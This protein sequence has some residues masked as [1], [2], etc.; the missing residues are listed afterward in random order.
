[1]YLPGTPSTEVL[2]NSGDSMDI[3]HTHD[4]PLSRVF[5][6]PLHPQ[7]TTTRT[8]HLT[9]SQAIISHHHLLPPSPP[10]RPPSRQPVSA[11]KMPP[12]KRGHQN[13]SGVT[14]QT[15]DGVYYADGRYMCQKL[16]NGRPCNRQMAGNSHSISS[17]NSDF[18]TEGS[19]RR[20][21]AQGNFI[22]NQD[23]CNHQSRRFPAILSHIRRRHGFK[24]SSD[25]LKAHYGIPLR[26]QRK[27]GKAKAADSKKP[28]VDT[29][30]DCD[31]NT[32]QESEGDNDAEE[33]PEN[34]EGYGGYG[35]YD[36]DLIDP[37]L[38]KWDR[39]RDMDDDESG[40]GGSG[41]GGQILSSN[42]IAYTEYNTY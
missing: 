5:L 6:C 17:H 21:M 15:A 34:Y 28:P 40:N 41:L 24:G 20:Q 3:F 36:N 11:A 19:Y 14:R 39:D 9:L 42:V 10:F 31:E 12:T 37:V 23:G 2:G 18:H 30:K 22:C 13:T 26:P 32:H 27:N 35:G 25:P 7:D 33:E 38:R 4:I 29:K 16:E 1:M 8:H